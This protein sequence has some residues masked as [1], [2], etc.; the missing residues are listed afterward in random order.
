MELNESVFRNVLTNLC[1]GV[2]LIDNDRNIVYWNKGAEAITGYSSET[3]LGKKC[4]EVLSIVYGSDKVD[5][6]SNACKAGTQLCRETNEENALIR[7]KQGYMVPVL[8]CVSPILSAD[9]EVIGVAEMFHDLSWKEAALDRIAELNKITLIDPL[10]GVGN[11][12][13]A[14]MIVHSKLEELKRYGLSFGISYVDVDDFKYVNDNFGHGAGDQLLR[15]IAKT[16]TASLRPY[17]TLCRLGGDEF[18]VITGNVHSDET[19]EMLSNRFCELAKISTFHANDKEVSVTIS[20]GS[21]MA[22]VNDTVETIIG[23][24]DK[25]MYTSKVAGKNHASV[26]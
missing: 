5:L 15:I 25:L 7:H 6:C 22:Q 3:V 18:M 13:Y 9:N 16:L 10:T 23:R 12:R 24:A 8:L 19:L 4:N 14:E 26:G 21:T 17:D 1:D 11:R 2:R 20:V